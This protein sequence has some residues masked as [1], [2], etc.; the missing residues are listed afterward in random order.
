METSNSQKKTNN[1]GELAAFF[2][3]LTIALKYKYKKIAGDSKLV[4]KWW[5]NGIY[6]EQLPIC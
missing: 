5:S 2:I 6:K 4:I 3:A 1:Y